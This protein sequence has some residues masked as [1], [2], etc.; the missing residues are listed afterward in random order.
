MASSPDQARA[1]TKF[2]S[3][4]VGEQGKKSEEYTPIGG[5]PE[6][7]ETG[8]ASIERLMALASYRRQSASD[9]IG[10]PRPDQAG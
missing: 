1:P 3:A 10:R 4:E 7:Y 5:Q 6:G 2:C 8:D 9:G